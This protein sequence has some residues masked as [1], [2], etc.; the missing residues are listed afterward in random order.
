MSATDSSKENMIHF[1]VTALIRPTRAAGPNMD[2]FKAR[3]R[4]TNE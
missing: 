2:G 3:Q 1:N 4:V